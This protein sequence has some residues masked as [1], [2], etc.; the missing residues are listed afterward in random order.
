MEEPP[1]AG[2]IANSAKC[3]SEREL[4]NGFTHDE[5]MLLMIWAGY[6]GK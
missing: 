5:K 1:A 3:H 4:G 2:A 6:Q